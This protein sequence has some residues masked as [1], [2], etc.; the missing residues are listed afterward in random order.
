MGNKHKFLLLIIMLVIIFQTTGCKKDSMEGIDIVT[1]NYPNE[2]I[3][4]SLYGNHATISS[5]YPDGVDI[6]TYKI[7]NK[8]K[9]DFSQKELFVYNGLIEKERNLAVDLLDLNENL[10]IIDSAYVLETDY[11]PEELWLNPSSMLMIAQNIRLGL[12]EY[13]SSTVLQQEIDEKYESLK[14]TLSELDAD[15]RIAVENTNNKSLVVADSTLKYLEKFGINVICID[16]DAN[17]KTIND[18]IELIKNGTISY[19][20]TFKDEKI[21]DTAKEILDNYKDVKKQELHKLDNLSDSD[22]E[23]KKDYLSIMNENLELIKQ[24]LYQ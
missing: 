23:S 15:Y 17:E 3:I 18:A 5:I 6:N 19:I 20:Y 1:T 10:K 4:N 22:R 16:S 24:E 21:N 2:Y 13:I 7:N 8:Q 9:K 14:I 11:S 12:K